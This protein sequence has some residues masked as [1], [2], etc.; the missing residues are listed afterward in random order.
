MSH[1]SPTT[2]LFLVLSMVA[3]GICVA[4]QGPVNA[5][6]RLAVGSPVLSATFSFFSGA[7]V[8]FSVMA[9]GLFGGSGSGLRGLQIAPPWAFLGGVLGATYVLG[10][11]IAIPQTGSVVVICSGIV[12]QMIGSYLIDTFGYL[13][14][15]R[16]PF[17]WLRLCGIGFLLLGVFLVQR[18]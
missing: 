10:S 16:V 12:G 17:N 6:L 8:L 3:A 14:V 5:R 15:E 13:G 11:I 2:R 18:K 1:L 9:T 7:L 4:I